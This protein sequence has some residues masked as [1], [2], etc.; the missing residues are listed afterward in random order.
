[1]R[2]TNMTDHEFAEYVKAQ[3]ASERYEFVDGVDATV[4][5]HELG[6]IVALVV[7]DNARGD[8]WIFII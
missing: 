5:R 4:W 8:R 3:G 7:Y 6:G 2:L 1:M